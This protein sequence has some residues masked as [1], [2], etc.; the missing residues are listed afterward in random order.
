MADLGKGGH[1]HGFTYGDGSIYIVNK[2]VYKHRWFKF[3]VVVNCDI[4]CCTPPAVNLCIHKIVRVGG[5]LWLDKSGGTE[6]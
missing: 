2:R 1:I 6:G 4:T 3:S 5:R